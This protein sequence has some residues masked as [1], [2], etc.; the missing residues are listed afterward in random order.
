MNSINYVIGIV[1]I[2]PAALFS[3]GLYQIV[4]DLRLFLNVVWIFLFLL[5]FS[6]ILNK[7]I[8]VFSKKELTE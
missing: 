7:T 2:I 8:S 1:T 3:Y 4:P 5:I 6:L